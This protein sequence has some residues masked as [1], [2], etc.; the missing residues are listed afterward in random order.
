[1]KIFLL[2]FFIV[3]QRFCFAEEKIITG[4]IIDNKTKLPV[5]YV[6]IGIAFKGSGTIS[7][8]Q[9]LFK[10]KLNSNINSTDTIYFSHIGYETSKYLVHDMKDTLN[11]IQLVSNAVE[12][13][14]IAITPQKKRNKVFGRNSRG[15]GLMHYNF[16]TAYEKEV[17]DRLSKEIGIVIKPKGDCILEDLNIYISSN[18]FSSLKFRLNFYKIEDGKPTA[19][20]IFKEIVFEI[21]NQYKGWFNVD[22]TPYNI[23]LNKDMGEVAATIQW[24]QSK[25]AFESSK[26]LGI[27]TSV[28][29]TETSF[30]REKSMDVWKIEKQ[31][32]SIYFNSSCTPD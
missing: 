13:N 22:L 5:A 28:S 31:S 14:E 6:N 24:V 26:Y 1:M 20:V 2:F 10:L 12:L 9:G 18:E 23:Y 25:K 19:L 27:S 29:P 11:T 15:L 3:L 7:S 32:L 16:Y 30:F 8:E 4:R 21:S 17:D